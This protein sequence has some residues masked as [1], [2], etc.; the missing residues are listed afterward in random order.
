M[1]K[2]ANT[3]KLSSFSN[4]LREAFSNIIRNRL[5]TI[6]T[7]ITLSAGLFLFGLTSALTLNVFSI[8]EKLQEDFKLEAYIDESFDMAKR[9]ELEA[10]LKKITNVSEVEFLSREAAFEEFKKEFP[11]PELLVGIDDGTILRHTYRITLKDLKYS[12]ETV[13]A[14]EKV[15]GIAKVSQLA[16]EMQAFL[17][18][19]KKLQLATI[20]ISI[21]LGLLA[22]LIITNTINISIFS[23][24]KQINIMKYVGATDGYI[25]APFVL[26]G[27]FIGLFA[28]LFSYAGVYYLYNVALGTMGNYGEDIGFLSLGQAM[29]PLAGIVG[30]M[31]IL[32]GC[33]GSMISIRKHLKV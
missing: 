19:V 4:A 32:L 28:A 24:R 20:I 13:K 5:M 27:F 6:A 11:Q 17:S 14:L 8:T 2:G 18:I 26:E 22:V 15:Q 33:L 23:R 31:G 30:G 16:N 21:I 25:R 1:Q 10:A 29:L 12:S 7:I 3:M 9:P